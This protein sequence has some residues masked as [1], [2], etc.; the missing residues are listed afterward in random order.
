M[1]SEIRGRVIS[2]NPPEF[3]AGSY[4]LGPPLPAELLKPPFTPKAAARIAFFLGPLAGAL[5]TAISLRRMRHPEKARK[6]VTLALLAMV[7]LALILFFTP[8]AL[9]RV[10]GFGAEAAFYVM[11]HRF[12]EREFAEWQAA[13]ATSQPS[14]GW[15]A[16][17]WGFA[18]LFLALL[19]F[20]A[21][22][23]VLSLF[24]IQPR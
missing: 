5:V 13:N 6:G 17:G 3:E 23:V 1:F 7:V 12:Q 2:T 20:F 21:L 19:I 9:A 15:K 14:N 24:G 4:S 16:I 11:F 22:A 10:V 18:G 8:E